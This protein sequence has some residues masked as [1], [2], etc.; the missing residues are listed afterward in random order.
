MTRRIPVSCPTLDGNEWEYVRQCIESSYISSVGAFVE[1]FEAAFAAFC[2][3]PY[4]VACCN[5]TAAL[6]LALLALGVKPGDEVLAPTLTYVAVANAV[7][8]CGATPVFID[9]EAETMNLDPARIEERITPRT[10]GIIVVHLYGH[11]ADMDPILEIARRRSLFVIEDAAEAHGAEYRGRVA[12]SLGDVATFSFFGNKILTTGEGGM[13]T[14]RDPELAQRLRLLRGQ[15]MQPDR[16]F[17]F[18]MVGYNYRMTNIQAALGLAQLERIES[19]REAHRRV[20]RWYGRHLDGLRP[21]LRLPVEK[22][23]ARHAYWLYTVLLNDT[24]DCSRDEVIRALA[25]GGIET[26]PVFYPMHIMPPYREP[27][28]AYPVAERLGSRGLSLPTHGQLN[29]DDV[30][31]IAATLRRVCAGG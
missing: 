3:T 24:I 23:W 17:W 12:G 5:G 18:P 31:Y 10:R 20:A 7:R 25:A 13:L 27:D 9:S 26:R 4:A 16:R 8:Y 19:H 29:E 1:R 2:G 11:P 6:H 22:E 28:G 14:L 30:A 21:L 15:G